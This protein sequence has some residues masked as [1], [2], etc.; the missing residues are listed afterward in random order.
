[1]KKY[2]YMFSNV[3]NNLIGKLFLWYF[4]RKFNYNTYELRVRGQNLK[5]GM[6]RS[7]PKHTKLSEARTLRIYVERKVITI[8]R[9]IYNYEMDHSE[10]SSPENL[11]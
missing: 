9:V 11:V 6:R 5:K 2:E 8:N 7:N 1:M 10:H 3:P 4:K